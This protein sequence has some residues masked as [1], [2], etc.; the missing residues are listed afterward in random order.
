MTMFILPLLAG[1]LVVGC[2]L[3]YNRFVTLRNLCEEGF[4]GI[5][6]QLKRRHDLIP[7]LV[8]VVQGAAGFEK[9]L[10]EAVIT[11]RARAVDSKSVDAKQEAER[12]LGGSLGRLLAVAEAYPD[13]KASQNFLQLQAQ[14]VQLETDLSMARRYFNAC[15]RDHNTYGQT[16]PA[17]LLAG[18]AN[19]KAK[20]YFLADDSERASPESKF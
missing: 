3:L 14:L 2:V 17:S 9:E 18:T 20:E 10:L 11:A 8:A 19:F 12:S 7:K 1:F 5:D 16:L 15:V 6:V 13:L 4:S